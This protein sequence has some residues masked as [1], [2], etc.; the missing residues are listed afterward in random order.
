M[1]L[2]FRR[3]HVFPTDEEV[4]HT[5]YGETCFCNPKVEPTPSANEGKFHRIVIHNS[6]DGREFKEGK[7]APNRRLLGKRRF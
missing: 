1:P 6:T 7:T 2:A 4:L 5:T 3:W